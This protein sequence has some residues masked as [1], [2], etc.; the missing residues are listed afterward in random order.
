MLHSKVSVTATSQVQVEAPGHSIL[1]HDM[2]DDEDLNSEDA[3]KKKLSHCPAAH[4]SCL[5]LGKART[6]LSE[7]DW[8]YARSLFQLTDY[9]EW[10]P[11]VSVL[12]VLQCRQNMT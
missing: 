11:S 3:K 9:T 2:P 1:Q 5:F 8:Q 7:Q 12:P 6:V 10:I 4:P